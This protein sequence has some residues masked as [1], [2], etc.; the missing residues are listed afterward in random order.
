MTEETTLNALRL[1]VKLEREIKVTLQQAKRLHHL[2]LGRRKF[3]IC[4]WRPCMLRYNV[5]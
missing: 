2:G 3:Y 5:I 4:P 1:N